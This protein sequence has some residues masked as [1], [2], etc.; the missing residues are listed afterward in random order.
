MVSTPD[1]F[2]DKFPMSPGPSVAVRNHSARKSLRLF[3]KVLGVKNKTVVLNVGDSKSKCKEIRPGSMLCLSITN[4]TG[5]TKIN[6][7]VKKSLYN[8]ILQHP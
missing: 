3:S 5:H 1:K 2:T 8:W 7:C 4:R 6:E